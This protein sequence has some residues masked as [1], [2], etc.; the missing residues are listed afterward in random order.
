VSPPAIHHHP[1][2]TCTNYAAKDPLAFMC[3]GHMARVSVA[4]RAELKAAHTKG[5]EA[6]L[7]IARRAA[8]EAGVA[9]ESSR[10]TD[11]R[12]APGA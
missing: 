4:T 5:P 3:A 12:K 2:S 6:F 10:V 11:A 9:V 8:I 7:P 1:H